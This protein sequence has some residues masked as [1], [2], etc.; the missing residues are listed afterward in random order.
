[1]YVR[2]CE[3]A[4]MLKQCK[5]KRGGGL[6]VDRCR[7]KQ[8]VGPQ[9]TDKCEDRRMKRWMNGDGSGRKEG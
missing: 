8:R 4:K 5:T 3:R 7:K 9:M 6:F 2:V 1:M